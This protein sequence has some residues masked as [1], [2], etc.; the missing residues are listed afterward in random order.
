MPHLLV[1]SFAGR[2]RP[3]ARGGSTAGVQA[4]SDA[5]QQATGAQLWVWYTNA[6]GGHVS[7]DFAA[8]TAE[9]TGLGTTDVLLV[10]ALDDRAYGYWKGDNV[11]ISN[12][13]LEQ[14]LSQDME[15]ALRSNDY[16]GAITATAKGLVVAMNGGPVTPGESA[17]PGATTTP[18]GRPPG[19]PRRGPRRAAA[20][21]ARR[22]RQSHPRR[23]G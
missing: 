1:G 23:D 6:L 4:T 2:A 9:A 10:I 7:G 15:P 18:A 16:L 22:A 8:A 19:R 14:V 5:L 13:E 20:Q 21:A 12:A 11:R 17:I 3:W